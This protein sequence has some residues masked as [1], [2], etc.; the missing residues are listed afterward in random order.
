MPSREGRRERRAMQA[1][2]QRWESLFCCALR[3]FSPT[4]EPLLEPHHRERV[5]VAVFEQLGLDPGRGDS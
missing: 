5:K 3:P 1:I 4:P 2:L